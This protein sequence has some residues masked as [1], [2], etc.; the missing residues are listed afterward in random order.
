M[1]TIGAMD[2][3]QYAKA[4]WPDIISNRETQDIEPAPADR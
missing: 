4:V 1:G 3:D 2:L